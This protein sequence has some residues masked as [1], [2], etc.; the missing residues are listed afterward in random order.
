MI[1][2]CISLLQPLY[3]CQHQLRKLWIPPYTVIF[4]ACI[5]QWYLECPVS[6]L[7]NR[8]VMNRFFSFASFITTS[9]ELPLCFVCYYICSWQYEAQ[10][11]E[12]A[13]RNETFRNGKQ[14]RKILGI[15]GFL[16][17]VHRPEFEIIDNTTFRKLYLFP[18]PGEER[19]MP[20][21]LGPLERGNLNHWITQ[22]PSYFECYMPSSD[23]L[24]GLVVRVLYYRSR[25]PRFDSRAL[26]KKSNGSGTGSTQP[27]EYFWGATW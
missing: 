12:T 25:G 27:R 26:Q 7:L 19:E 3:R 4:M 24:C 11:T 13:H 20:T 8:R 15:T 23:R 5:F 17:L 16:D 10:W 18:S 14:A 22:K 9:E 6:G 21:V 1:Y 2:S